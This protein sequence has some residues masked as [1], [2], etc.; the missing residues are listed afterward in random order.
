MANS[1]ICTTVE[2]ELR[3]WISTT[4]AERRVRVRESAAA[5]TR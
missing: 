4:P 2:I 1:A 5:T 3:P